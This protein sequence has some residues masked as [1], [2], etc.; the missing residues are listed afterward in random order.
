MRSFI[1][2]IVLLMAVPR[3]AVRRQQPRPFGAIGDGWNRAT[4]DGNGRSSAAPGQARPIGVPQPRGD[5]RTP[6]PREEKSD[7]RRTARSAGRERRNGSGAAEAVR[8]RLRDEPCPG[9]RAQSVFVEAPC[10]RRLSKRSLD[11]GNRQRPTPW[12]PVFRPLPDR[13]PIGN[14]SRDGECRPRHRRPHSGANVVFVPY[15]APVVVR[16]PRYR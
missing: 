10:N 3:Y 2:G 12:T 16:A 13:E 11:P 7:R 8:E 14:L 9:R 1:L 6:S 15:A 5:A 4:C